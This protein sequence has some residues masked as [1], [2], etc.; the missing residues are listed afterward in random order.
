MVSNSVS[1]IIFREVKEGD[2]RKFTATSNDSPSGGGAR[3]FRYRPFDRFD[4]IFARVLPG[5]KSESRVRNG[6]RTT[7]TLYTAPV[8][9]P[10]NNGSVS[11]HELTFEP[12]TTAREGEGRLAQLDKYDLDPPKNEGRVLLLIIE[13]GGGHVILT[14]FSEKDLAGKLWHPTVNAFFSKV[15]SV[16]SKRS[17]NQGFID[18]QSQTEWIKFT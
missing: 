6:M 7:E 1:R 8:S 10:H 14:F 3:D 2:L 16:P 5:R 4:G 17:A 11:R 13:D 9:V 12:P 15:F 18:F